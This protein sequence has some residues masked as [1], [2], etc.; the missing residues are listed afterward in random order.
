MLLQMYLYIKKLMKN[1]NF[2]NF[3]EPNLEHCFMNGKY[4][5]VLD[6]NNEVE[7]AEHD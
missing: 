1:K 3:K 5:V 4:L 6:Q 2:M 7:Y